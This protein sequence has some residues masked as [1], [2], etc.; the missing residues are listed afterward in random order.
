MPSSSC[1]KSFS[2]QCPPWLAHTSC[3]AQETNT[4]TLDDRVKDACGLPAIRVTYQLHDDD[5][6]TLAWMKDREKEIL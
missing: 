5:V 4:I 6:K 2:F 1:L 3:L